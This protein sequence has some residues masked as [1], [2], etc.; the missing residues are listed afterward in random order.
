ML[1]EIKQVEDTQPSEAGAISGYEAEC[2]CGY[3]VRRSLRTIAVMDAIEH[4]FASTY[5]NHLLNGKRSGIMPSDDGY[6][7]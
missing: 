7:C 6:D 3:K 1:H 2:T 4:C 5:K